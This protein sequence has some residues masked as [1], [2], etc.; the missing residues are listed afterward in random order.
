MHH[1]LG[2][3]KCDTG[4]QGQSTSRHHTAVPLL[5]EQRVK[6]RVSLH[7]DQVPGRNIAFTATTYFYR[8]QTDEG[9]RFG[10]CKSVCTGTEEWGFP[11]PLV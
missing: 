5:D 11:W 4:M 6:S 2:F 8:V 10:K 7:L 9:K 3:H 1:S